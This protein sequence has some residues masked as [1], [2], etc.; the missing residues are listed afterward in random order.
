[1]QLKCPL[2][3]DELEVDVVLEEGQQVCCE[4]CN[5]VFIYKKGEGM[6]QSRRSN[7]LSVTCPHCGKKY[8][9]E[10][11]RIGKYVMCS[12][13]SKLFQVKGPNSSGPKM[14][15]KVS[16][17]LNSP[18]RRRKK[19]GCA[20]ALIKAITAVFLIVIAVKVVFYPDDGA[21]RQAIDDFRKK[22]SM[23][24]NWGDVARTARDEVSQHE[25]ERSEVKSRG[26]EYPSQNGLGLIKN[27]RGQI[28]GM[29]GHVL[30]EH[31]SQMRGAG[32]WCEGLKGVKLRC[33]LDPKVMNFSAVEFEYLKE[34][35][36]LWGIRL[37]AQAGT[38]HSRESVESLL[39]ALR[40]KIAIEYGIDLKCV[41]N[42][43]GWKA[44]LA[45]MSGGTYYVFNSYIFEQ[46]PTL[47]GV[48]SCLQLE[49]YE[50]SVGSG[51]TIELLLN[52]VQLQRI[53]GRKERASQ[54]PE[55]D[56]PR[57]RQ[58]VF[59]QKKATVQ[60][61]SRRLDNKQVWRYSGDPLDYYLLG[62]YK[63]TR[64]EDFTMSNFLSFETIHIAYTAKGRIGC[65]TLKSE[66]SAGLSVSE[67]DRIVE[68]MIARCN[69]KYGPIDWYV[70]VN[71]QGG[72]YALGKK[73]K[74][75]KIDKTFSVVPNGHGG[76][77][78]TLISATAKREDDGY[79]SDWDF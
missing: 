69:L 64:Q 62:T 48:P 74:N 8:V 58:S 55:V 37:I 78:S 12:G 36:C 15:P 56:G 79:E 41:R 19:S 51:Y 25:K 17:N 31:K 46:G 3:G 2:C 38:H 70:G 26:V 29:M 39:L 44:D 11:A 47:S 9:V 75:G 14:G 35:P 18:N 34:P 16:R 77:S 52:C 33:Q 27:N 49:A 66:D 76:I 5:K 20:G 67:T 1:M 28:V 13:C 57:W 45:K 21:I 53:V 30:G 42:D 32:Y 71:I 59:T 72:K 40:N 23:L 50:E 54:V 63:S 61:S 73:Y 65:I 43:R 68:R 10:G 6:R 60:A 24:N 4:A 7:S 22:M